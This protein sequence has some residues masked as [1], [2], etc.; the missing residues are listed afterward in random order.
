MDKA[1]LDNIRQIVQTCSDEELESFLQF[2]AI[3]SVAAAIIGALPSD[4]R[5]AL[6]AELE[7]MP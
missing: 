4:A 7:K 3:S 6:L 5:K 1:R 2:Q